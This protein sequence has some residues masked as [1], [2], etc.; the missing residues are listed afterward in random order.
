M[1]FK[2]SYNSFMKSINIEK[3]NKLLKILDNQLGGS[4]PFIDNDSDEE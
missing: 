4:N 1:K 3:R 2:I